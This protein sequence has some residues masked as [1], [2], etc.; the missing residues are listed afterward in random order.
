MATLRSGWAWAL[1]AVLV[2]LAVGRW[3]PLVTDRSP[4]PASARA[5]RD[6]AN[7]ATIKRIHLRI[8]AKELLVEDLAAGKRSLLET[9]ALFRELDRIPPAVSRPDPVID[10]PIR[11]ENPTEDEWQ[12]LWVLAYTRTLLQVTH[13]D[14]EASVTDRLV[15][16]F[17]AERRDRGTVRLRDPQSLESVPTILARARD[18]CE[19]DRR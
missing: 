1:L 14:R 17:E 2:L 5:D 13:P 12:C 15:R 8:R 7:A 11:P 9:A 16:E 18:G 6:D 10:P 19:A 4:D 3:G